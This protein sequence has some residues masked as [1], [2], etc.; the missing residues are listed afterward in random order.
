MKVKSTFDA[1]N[2]TYTADS[3]QMQFGWLQGF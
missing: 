2:T 3:Q 1:G